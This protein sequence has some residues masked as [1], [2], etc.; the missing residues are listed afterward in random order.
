MVQNTIYLTPVTCDEVIRY[1]A[2]LKKNK[3]PG[4]D[5]ITSEILKACIHTIAPVI[6]HLI[7]VIF[8]TGVCPSHFKTAL[9][10]PIHKGGSISDA[11]N[12]RPIS[13][14]SSISKIFERALKDRIT[15]FID[16]YN[17][18]SDR[19]F[20]F[21]SG[22]ST[23][24]ALT[25]VVG[26]IY[27]AV[28]NKKPI[29]G[30]FIDLT[31]AFD[32]IDHNILLYKLW[33]LGFRGPIHEL[34]KSYL[35]GRKQCVKVEDTLSEERETNVGLPQGTILAPDLF[36]IYI[37]DLLFMKLK[38][39]IFSYADDTAILV[40][41]ETWDEVESRASEDLK[42]VKD[43]FDFN[44]LTM[45]DKKTKY[46]PFCSYA[47]GLPQFNQINI[48]GTNISING[49]SSIKYLGITLDSH[50]RWDLHTEN[51]NKKIRSLLYS[52][53]K[54]KNILDT[55]TLL[56]IYEALVESVIRYGLIVW[57]GI[58]KTHLQTLSQTQ[59][60]LLK[61]ILKK[62]ITYSSDKLFRDNKIFRIKHMYAEKLFLY[63]DKRQNT[64]M[65]IYK[66]D[67]RT[68]D[69]VAVPRAKKTI[70]QNY[71]EYSAPRLY[72]RVPKTIKNIK[73]PKQK[74]DELKNWILHETNP[75][76]N[77]L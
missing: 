67:I 23:E 71:F 12:Y 29:L 53:Y 61:I 21:R 74:R 17:I 63:Q 52:F 34:M 70:G 47:G 11:E 31:K 22:V 50:L 76:V 18:L 43:W 2:L 10:V 6:T 32:T 66:H 35:T 28:D 77:Q 72:N 7:N 30:I 33:N 39:E 26:R 1:I 60:K 64:K 68:K 5:K 8:K 42:M 69:D 27:E 15:G 48:L 24:D 38:G 62:E 37:N 49:A 20:G 58:N 19:Q 16:R 56:L 14:T 4:I 57:G 45:N 40:S 46:L 41:G 51:I 55:K 59:K 9:I 44:L 36:K 3:A 75:I 54:L 13:L 65:K 73:N 25:S